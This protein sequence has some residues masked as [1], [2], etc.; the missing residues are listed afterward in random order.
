MVKRVLFVCLGNICRS[1][2][3][4]GLF[5]RMAKE[6]AVEVEV[7]PEGVLDRRHAGHREV[8]HRAVG[9]HDDWTIACFLKLAIP[10]SMR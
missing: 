1:P 3:A 6:A 2:M 8:H 9:F 4:E 7:E 5:R 10:R